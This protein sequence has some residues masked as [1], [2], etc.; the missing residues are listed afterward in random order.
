VKN[1]IMIS[2]GAVLGANAR[3][4]VGHLISRLGGPAFPLQTLVINST[5]SLALGYV[6]FWCTQNGVVGP[7]R[8]ALTIGFCGAYTTF[9][10]FAHESL[11]LLQGGQ[12]QRFALHVAANNLFS[13]GGVAAGM[14]L[15]RIKP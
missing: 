7:W 10:A 12:W 8:L 1:A 6:L 4:L 13:I 14:A 15:A 11:A 2:I 5:G 9:S 3:Y